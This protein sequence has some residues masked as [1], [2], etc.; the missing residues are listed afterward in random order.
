MLRDRELEGFGGTAEVEK[1]RGLREMEGIG[2]SC[3]SGLNNG[4]MQSE[5]GKE[6][7]GRGGIASS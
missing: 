4:F 7:M 3:E 2:G 5:G 1:I 6:F